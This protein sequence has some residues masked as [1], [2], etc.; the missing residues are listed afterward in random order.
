V[1]NLWKSSGDVIKPVG[2]PISGKG[3]SKGESL[4]MKKHK[5]NKETQKQRTNR[6]KAKTSRLMVS[7]PVIVT[8]KC[9]VSN[10]N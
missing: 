10:G 9:K 5:N 6:K 8:A 7:I 4:G 1:L 3:E 2:L